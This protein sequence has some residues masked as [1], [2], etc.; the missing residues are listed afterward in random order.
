MNNTDPRIP[1]SHFSLV[2][3][4]FRRHRD[5]GQCGYTGAAAAARKQNESEV[6]P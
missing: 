1:L 5:A 3:F 4:A 6:V 2:G